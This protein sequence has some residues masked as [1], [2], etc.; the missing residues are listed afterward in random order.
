MVEQ[1]NIPV[2]DELNAVR[3]QIKA[4]QDREAELRQ[5]LIANPDLREGNA[6]LAEVKEVKQQRTDL[7]ELRAV[8]PNLVDEYTYTL[9]TTHVV[10]SG[11]SEHGEIIPARRFRKA[12]KDAA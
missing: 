9:T 1:P 5:L 2:P 11:I 7:K 4:L 10:L 8:H 3:E 6:W 12:T